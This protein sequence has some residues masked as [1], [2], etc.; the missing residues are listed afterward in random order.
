[1]APQA[2]V[3]TASTA[4]KVMVVGDSISHGSSGDWTWRY[5]LYKHLVANNV[6][7]DLVGPKTGL[8]NMMTPES[9]DEDHTYADPA[10]DQDHEA[11]WGQPLDTEVGVIRDRV[12]TYQ[13][14]YL[15]VLLGIND[16]VWLSHTPT[17][18]EANL[19]TFIANAR[20]GNP[21]VKLVFSK[22]LPTQRAAD[23]TAFA[24]KVSDVNQRLVTVA[25]Q[26]TTTASPVVVADPT[27]E[28]VPGE[29]TWDG[30]HPNARGELR[31]AAAFADVL[32]SR[33]AVGA[34]YPRPYQEPPVGPQQAPVASVVSTGAGKADLSWTPSVGANQYWVWTQDDVLNAEW[35]KLP[36]PLTA[37]YNP[38]HMT[39]LVPGATYKWKVQAAKGNDAGAISNEVTLTVPGTP[40]AAPTAPSAAPGNRSATLSWTAAPNASGYLIHMRNLTLGETTFTQLPYPVAASPWVAEGL[41]NG[42]RYE[43]KVQSLNGR[44]AGGT[45]SAVAVT[46]TGPAPAGVTDLR[47]TNG[48]GEASLQWTEVPNATG[49][50]I[51]QRNVTAGETSFT[52]L[53]WPVPG[54]QWTAEDLVNGATYEFKIQSAN[55]LIDGGLSNVVT[56]RPTITAPAAPTGLSATAGNGTATLRWTAAANATGYLVHM[57]NV[58]A[59]ES[60]FTELPFP[61]SGTQ[62][63]AD[64]LVNG[65]TYEFKLQSVNGLVKGG[66]SS[67]VSVRPTVAPPAGPTNLSVSNG[68]REVTL[69]WTAATNATG[70]IVYMRNVSAGE[71][72]FTRLPF[73]V[74]GTRWTAELLTNGATYE[75][76]LQSE[77]GLIAGGYSATVTARPTG[78]APPAPTNLVA[79]AGDREA[80]LT[81]SMPANATCVY[82]YMRN[83]TAGESF[84]KLPIAIC[85]DSW[86]A[87]LLING[88]TY[89]FKLQAYDGLIAGGT[90]A[91]VSVRPTAPPPPGPESLTVTGGDHKATLQWTGASGATGYYIWV[92][93]ITFGKS[94]ERLP[95]AIGYRYF[96]ANNLVNG[97]TYEFKVQSVD[98]Y[99]AGGYSNTVAVVPLGPTPQVG[100]LSVTPKLGEATLSW[101]RSGTATGYYIWMRDV[102]AGQAFSQLEFAVS[103]PTF[104]AKFLVPGDRY[105]FKVQAVNG[106][107]RGAYSNT[108]GVSILLPAAPTGLTASQGG[109]YEAKLKWN[110]VPG[111]D[112]YIIYHG[113][114]SRPDED[115]AMTPL[116]FPVTGTSFT[117]GYLVDKGIHH[118]QVAATK[119]GRTGSRSSEALMSPLMTNPLFFQAQYRYFQGSVLSKDRRSVYGAPAAPSNGILVARAYIGDKFPYNPISD[120]R[121]N[122]DYRPYASARIHV[123][124]ASDGSPGNRYGR[125]GV[126]A[127]GSCVFSLCVDALPVVNSSS[128]ADDLD[129]VSLNYFWYSGT[130][131]ALTFNWKASNS[132]T[133]SIW[134]LSAHIDTR[135]DLQGVSAARLT[136]DH[137]PSYE[138]IHYPQLTANGVEDWRTLVTCGQYQIDGLYDSPGERRTCS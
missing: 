85:D 42:A 103:G 117:M 51:H 72:S 17:Q 130:G 22:L 60:D 11:T 113:V 109:A 88:A 138:V 8:E 14:D 137:F 122:P 53:P 35:T 110:A 9:G 97:A 135:V 59:G 127:Q 29:H 21:N 108:V 31:I 41:I 58:T 25:A 13:P 106:L 63:L 92:R 121:V 44:I 49:Y 7:V 125:F 80:V 115:A 67:T 70:Y 47:V 98:G 128:P 132:Q 104:Q 118:F 66:F 43:F 39:D 32:A 112:G 69:S 52:R 94:W 36:I 105:E 101:G 82:A 5:R 76:K 40:P 129:T 54:P 46:P 56:A 89:E 34:S 2:V 55:G 28:F 61:V 120:G 27:G 45:S 81:W 77:S 134:P 116:P 83:V 90:T 123:A 50:Y 6:T 102:T 75:F 65:A 84:A 16:L 114:S 68:N 126:L 30:V 18:V 91:A 71:S 74:P 93:E 12:T 99:I 119:Y 24:A 19:R 87:G 131:S 95:Y 10:F 33:F 86:T 136:T 38:W 96:V 20:L 78:P 124:W 111:A 64:L 26:L 62:W 100:T 3:P 79:K 37:D 57:R 73:A 1:M 107:Q 15:L 133:N 48:N 23:E 4:G